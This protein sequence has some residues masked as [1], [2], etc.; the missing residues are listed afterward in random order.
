M[1]KQ[2]GLL[3]DVGQT[4]VNHLE[5]E[6]SQ[7]ESDDS[8]F[9]TLLIPAD[10]LS[11][12]D[13]ACRQ[14]VE[15]LIEN[16]AAF[17]GK[18][19]TIEVAQ[20]GLTEWARIFGLLQAA[21]AWQSHGEWIERHQPRFGPD[22][23]ERFTLS[24]TIFKNDLAQEVYVRKQI[25][26]RMNDLLQDDGILITPTTP[27]TA[28]L[29]GTTGSDLTKRRSALQQLC[30]VAGLSGLPQVTLPWADVHGIPVG[31]SL[32]AGPGQDM[33]LLQWVE[34]IAHEISG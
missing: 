6:R 31:L 2:P 19:E 26:A 10:M 23:A 28:P 24:S 7:A 32:I 3:K 33:R 18:S 1:T 20:E 29:R 13:Q 4:I 14:A 22:I 12:T 27:G 17:V 15:P 11:V 16:I 21:E 30:C 34:E 8:R 9:R 5:I 25:C